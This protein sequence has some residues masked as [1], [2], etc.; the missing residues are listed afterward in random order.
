MPKRRC[1]FNIKLK[2]QFPN[3]RDANEI[4]KVLCTE[5]RIEEFKE[6]CDFVNVEFKN[7]ILG[8]VK[9]RW[10]S[11]QPAVT[12]ILKQFFDNPV[13][14]AWLYFIQ[15]QLKVVCDTITRTESDNISVSEV[16]EKLEVVCGKIR[17]RQSQQF[18]IL[19]LALIIEDLDEKKDIQQK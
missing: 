1:G 7:S 18:F 6:L 3:L 4:E 13:S 14:I 16:Y 11:L 15:T 2:T 12:T 19:K 9:T 17:N 10:L 8:T 5:F